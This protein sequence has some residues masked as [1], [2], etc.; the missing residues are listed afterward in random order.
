MR[1]LKV[2]RPVDAEFPITA[3]LLQENKKLWPKGHQGVD[4]GS[5]RD[6]ETKKIVRPIFGAP[7][8]AVLNGTVQIA[9]KDPKGLLGNRIWIVSETEIGVVRHGYCHL[10][11]IQKH[12]KAGAHVSGLELIGCVGNSGVNRQG[13]PLFPHLHFQ[14]EIEGTR[15]LVRPLFL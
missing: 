8:F 1:E 11:E 15:E 6:P 7:V 2:L 14:L 9:G 12:I 4:F 3:E 5:V 13:E 10:S